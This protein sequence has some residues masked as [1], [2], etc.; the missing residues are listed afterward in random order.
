M[1]GWSSGTGG[2]GVAGAFLYSGLTQVGLSPRVTLLI[3]LAVPVATL[4]SYFL[5]LAAPPA[6]P[7]WRSRER[8]YTAVTSEER[9]G[10]MD[11]SEEEEEGRDKPH[12]GSPFTRLTFVP[13]G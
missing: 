1:G 9:Q 5:L 13:S 2:A 11:Q 10:L 8:E 6:L 12:P 7:Q 3:M 4:V